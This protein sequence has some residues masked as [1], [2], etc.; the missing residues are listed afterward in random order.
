LFLQESILNALAEKEEPK[1]K[2]SKKEKDDDIKGMF[3]DD[4]KHLC[5]LVT[6]DRGLCG[7]V[8]SSLTRSLRRELNAAA[9]EKRSVRVLTLGDKGRAQIARDYAPIVARAIDQC[10]DKDPIFPLAASLAARIVV[11]PYDVLTL[12]YNHYENQ[13]KFH[14]TFAKFPQL[15]S[16]KTGQM[17]AKCVT[18]GVSGSRRGPHPPAPTSTLSTLSPSP[19]RPPPPPPP[20]RLKGYDLEPENDE[21]LTNLQE[22]GI[23]SA[24]FYAMLETTACETS[25]RVMAMDSATENANDMVHR[26]SLDYNRARQAKITTELTEIISGAES[27]NAGTTE[28]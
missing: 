23:A 14:N 8:N 21:V 19:S 7:A 15:A 16:M 18:N 10:F 5:V 26:L 28:D 2:D 1:A 17:P 25:Q 20:R 4:R 3:L 13:A 22:Y 12:Y 24:L 11:E 27:L 6:T 9:K